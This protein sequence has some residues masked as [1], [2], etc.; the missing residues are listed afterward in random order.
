M[1]EVI[2]LKDDEPLAHVQIK[3]VVESVDGQ[4]ADYSVKYAVERGSAVGLHQRSIDLF[5]RM[6]YNVLALVRQALLTLEP[7][8]L[9]LEDGFDVDEA[10]VS[11]DLARR[12]GSRV[13]EISSRVRGLHHH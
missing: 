13:R 6:H 4:F 1:I 8:E 12:L 9:K 10:S 7:K 2:I 5:P 3:K 11:Q